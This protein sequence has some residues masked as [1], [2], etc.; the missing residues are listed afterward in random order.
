[1]GA[2]WRWLALALLVCSL[3]VAR[4]EDEED[5]LEVNT[6]EEDLGA[7]KE[8]SRTDSETVEREEQAIKLDGMSVAEMKLMRESAE[9]HVFQVSQ[10]I[11]IRCA[12]HIISCLRRL[13]STE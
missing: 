1:M 8:G 5:T 6:V 12:Y 13:R 2:A 10:Y 3:G 9:K 7:S 11:I 4:A